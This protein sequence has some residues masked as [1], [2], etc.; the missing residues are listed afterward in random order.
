MFF[1]DWQGL[2]RVAV[3][4]SLAYIAL[5]AFLRVSGKRTL[6]KMNAFDLIV[7]V[8]LGSTLA[9]VLLSRDVALAEGLLAFAILICA[10]FGVAWL[11]VRSPRF[12]RLIKAQPALIFFRGSSLI[13]ARNKE[14]VTEEEVDA[15]IRA[16][17]LASR[18]AVEAIILE[19]DGTF[20]IIRK[21]SG[22]RLDVLEH[23]RGVAAG[24]GGRA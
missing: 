22:D 2:L 9:T 10:Q 21:S 14:R 13:D 16:Q 20:S 4:G 1:N 19:T 12:Q 11:S 17:G 5:V 6:S 8:S 3:V 7:T 23:V 15:A 18:D 24:T